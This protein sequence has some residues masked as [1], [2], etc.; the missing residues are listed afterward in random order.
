[1]AGS[2][3]RP[4]QSLPLPLSRKITALARP[5]LV[6][7]TQS[8]SGCRVEK[9]S[10]GEKQHHMVM[11]DTSPPPA[12]QYNMMSIPLPNYGE[13]VP[14]PVALSGP[15]GAASVLQKPLGVFPGLEFGSEPLQVSCWSCHRQVT[16][17]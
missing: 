1:M 8:L 3:D 2:W 16:H 11:M 13:A 10:E 7:T 12:Q 4:D 14:A 17:F 15:T 5:G 6:S 9:M